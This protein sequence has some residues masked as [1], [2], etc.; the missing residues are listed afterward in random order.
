MGD[1]LQ[2]LHIQ[3][4]PHDRCPLGFNMATYRLTSGKP[5]SL[6]GP[7]NEDHGCCGERNAV[8]ILLQI[9]CPTLLLYQH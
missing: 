9:T 4:A 7:N 6:G 2:T 1:R 5:E 3:V 8:I